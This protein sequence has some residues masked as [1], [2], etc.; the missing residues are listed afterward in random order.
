GFAVD[1]LGPPGSAL[2]GRGS[3]ALAIASDR[4]GLRFALE[5]IG[6][7]RQ[8]SPLPTGWSF[9]LDPEGLGELGP[10]ARRRVAEGLRGL[11]CRQVTGRA[12]LEADALSLVFE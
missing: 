1:R 6:T 10:L 4:A 11:G 9:R 12:G 5:R 3:R 2:M 8:P 7:Q